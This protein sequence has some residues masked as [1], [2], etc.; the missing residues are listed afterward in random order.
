[1]TPPSRG[2]G[3]CRDSP[4]A[5]RGVP[6]PRRTPRCGVGRCSRMG[7]SSGTGRSP[8]LSPRP[9]RARCPFR[10]P[11]VPSGAGPS[12]LFPSGTGRSPVALPFRDGSLASPSPCPSSR[13]PPRSFRAEFFLLALR[14][15]RGHPLPLRLPSGLSP[16]PPSP[17]G[18]SLLPLPGARGSLHR[19]CVPRS[20]E[21]QPGTGATPGGC[22]GTRAGG[23][24]SGVSRSWWAEEGKRYFSSDPCSV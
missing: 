15:D 24:E 12:P 7:L 11:R 1:M 8:P 13:P 9:L 3:E 20:P 10:F 19:P 22:A 21:G 5:P 14:Q 18:R 16:F 6:G 4:A 17:Q 23:L 2:A